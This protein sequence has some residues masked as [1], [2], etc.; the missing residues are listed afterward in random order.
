MTRTTCNAL[1]GALGSL[2]LATLGLSPAVSAT[3]GAAPVPAGSAAFT[4][5]G[6]AS[7]TVPAGVC[8]IEVTLAGGGGG[9]GGAEGT[10][11]G[12]G[13]SG[14]VVVGTLPVSAGQALAI[15]VGGAGGDST[16]GW[17]PFASPGESGPA[18]AAVN[19]NAGAGGVGGGGV[20][21]AGLGS[22]G[23]GG[24]GA[25]SIA[26][27]GT[28]LVV[29]GGGG[30]G[31]AD[32]PAGVGGPGGDAGAAGADGVEVMDDLL[33]TADAPT[34]LQVNGVTRA[35]G[36]GAGTSTAGG[37]GGASV[38]V[39][40]NGVV[41]PA[42]EGDPEPAGDDGT[43]ANPAGVQPT[44]IMNGELVE[45]TAGSAGLGGAGASSGDGGGGG[46]GGVFGGGGGGA[47]YQSSG[48]GGGGGASLVPT[49]G[50][51]RATNA[52]DGQV[53]IAWSAGGGCTP[54]SALPS[55][56]AVSVGASPRF[57]G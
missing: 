45:A 23:G 3:E 6:D 56:S 46:G 16:S 27:A 35:T 53:T 43:G 57:T 42:P 24:G 34:A 47:G 4:T 30:G 18:E 17:V 2:A 37:A 8:Q 38:D 12:R 21:G 7:W 55:T 13:G 1:V 36:G 26:A 33:P 5:V 22:G 49:G 51:L 50:T 29:A 32:G 40:L 9:A 15:T 54:A 31:G 48:A 41:D 14:A 10:T 52:G 25:S 20:G 19:G 28:S 39:I 44:Q 11:G